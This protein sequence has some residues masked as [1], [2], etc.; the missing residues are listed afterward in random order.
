MAVYATYFLVCKVVDAVIGKI[1]NVVVGVMIG[2]VCES[3]PGIEKIT[4]RDSASIIALTSF[5][6]TNYLLRCPHKHR[7]SRLSGTL[8]ST[9]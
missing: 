4:T 7:R 5:K 1:I 2:F 9:R 8:L 6:Y 3:E